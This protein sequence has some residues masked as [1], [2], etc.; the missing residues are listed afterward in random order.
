MVKI[1]R[2]RTGSGGWPDRRR[3]VTYTVKGKGKKTGGICGIVALA[4]AAGISA[5]LYGVGYGIYSIV[6]MML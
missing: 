6:N 5:V 4:M 3:A 2:Q 1:P